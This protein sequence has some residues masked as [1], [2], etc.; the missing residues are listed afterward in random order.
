MKLTLAAAV[1]LLLG[2]ALISL[3]LDAGH[4]AGSVPTWYSETQDVADQ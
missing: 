4:A 3:R 2:A 1:T